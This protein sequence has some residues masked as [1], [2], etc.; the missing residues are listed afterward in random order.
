MKGKRRNINAKFKESQSRHAF[1]LLI[2]KDGSISE[3]AILDEL[4]SIRSNSASPAQSNRILKEYLKKDIF[5][6][7]FRKIYINESKCVDSHS[8]LPIPPKYTIDDTMAW[9]AISLMPFVAEIKTYLGYKKQIEKKLLLGQFEPVLAYISEIEADCGRSVWAES[10]KF[11]YYYFSRNDD[12]LLDYYKTLD[13]VDEYTAMKL[14]YEFGKSR[15]SSNYSYFLKSLNRQQ[16]DLRIKG[17]NKYGD[18]FKF[19]N[20]FDPSYE[21]DGLENIISIYSKSRLV[22]LY[23]FFIRMSK[24]LYLRGI[25]LPNT[26]KVLNEYGKDIGDSNLNR[27]YFSDTVPNF[28]NKTTSYLEIVDSYLRQEFDVVVEKCEGILSYDPGF[29]IL[30]EIYARSLTSQ[31][32]E[33]GLTGPVRNIINSISNILS[34]NKIED[35]K[36]VLSKIFLNLD[37]FDWSYHLKS[38]MEVFSSKSKLKSKN[39]DFSDMCNVYVNPFNVAQSDACMEYYELTGLDLVGLKQFV[40]LV[41]NADV[42]EFE[43]PMWRVYKTKAEY[44]F[45]LGQ[46]SDSSLYYKKMLSLKNKGIG[47]N[48]IRYKM[49]LS[50]VASNNVRP[51]VKEMAECLLDGCSAHLLPIDNA[52]ELLLK[53]LR[54]DDDDEFLIACAIVLHFYNHSSGL[55]DVTQNISNVVENLFCNNGV[56]DLSEV[57]V[58]DWEASLFI[59]T[60]VLTV[61]VIEGFIVLSSDEVD[62]YIF[63]MRVCREIL[64]ADYEVDKLHLIN[65]HNSLFNRMVL[66]SVMKNMKDGKI[67]VEKESLRTLLL[68]GMENDLSKLPSLFNESETMPVS[69]RGIKG[70]VTF[71]DNEFYM[72]VARMIDKIIFEYSSNK[73]YGLDNSLNVGIRHGGLVNH[74]WAPLMVSEIHVVKSANGEFQTAHILEDFKLLTIDASNYIKQAFKEFFIEIESCILDFKNNCYVDYGEF[75]SNDNRFFSFSLKR[76]ILD[77]FVDNFKNK[78]TDAEL[79]DGVF[80]L[81][82]EKLEVDLK[83]VRDEKLPELYRAVDEKFASLVGGIDVAPRE[84]ID[85]V[86]YAR[87]QFLIRVDDLKKW[88]DWSSESES[89]FYLGAAQ[90][91]SGNIVSSLY[92]STTI[93]RNKIESVNIQFDGRYFTT[94]TSIFTLIQENAV[95]HCGSIDKL[96]FEQKTSFR[97]DVLIIESKN[98]VVGSGLIGLP[99]NIKNINDLLDLNNLD[100]ASADS[101]S[102]IFKIKRI[103]TSKLK[104]ESDMKI[105]FANGEF[106]I[107]IKIFNV[108]KL[109][110]KG[111]D[112]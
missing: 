83:V 67:N 85:R 60:H 64:E 19:S 14:S 107:H 28:E 4:D 13:D 54:R 78:Y 87:S 79:I 41:N 37:V 27:I 58:G 102:G 73:L 56:T 101:G 34:E 111:G 15:S 75:A 16:E 33:C 31:G 97:D 92:P 32:S 40:C 47:D 12:G 48:E 74:L 61:D 62:S 44:F 39:Y 86:C 108:S 24:Y 57:S 42:D 77:K 96:K 98:R 23:E 50:D 93:L 22:D 29:S 49:L 105:S 66:S 65:E 8:I 95:K 36:E 82:D 91:N 100:R 71:T 84:L 25:G 99:E 112:E 70:G 30:Y 53:D 104:L 72:L 89:T 52:V 63:K 90:M 6:E 109:A 68:D 9:I 21:Y 94:F 81:L 103:I 59:L 1:S 35:N 88:F 17:L 46:Y 69:E 38:V 11:S 51:V 80:E 76:D 110:Y 3:K 18:F 20:L 7:A 43:L 55:R 5:V 26:K 106:S 10:V 45:R 2:G